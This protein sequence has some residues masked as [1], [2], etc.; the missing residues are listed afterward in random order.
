[1]ENGAGC[2][3]RENNSCKPSR[4]IRIR[5]PQNGSADVLIRV[6]LPGD[7]RPGDVLE[8]DTRYTQ[9]R[10][11]AVDVVK[12]CS[13]NEKATPKSGLCC[14]E[15]RAQATRRLIPETSIARVACQA[16]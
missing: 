15:M 8:F 7:A 10:V 16:S 14:V 13:A 3:A 1:M 11:E 9:S 5:A 6:D 4:W 12:S 2:D